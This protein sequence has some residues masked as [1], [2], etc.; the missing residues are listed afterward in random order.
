MVNNSACALLTI[1]YICIH[2]HHSTAN[3]RVSSHTDVYIQYVP[4]RLIDTLHFSVTALFNKCIR[5]HD[6]VVVD[7]GVYLLAHLNYTLLFNILFSG[8]GYFCKYLYVAGD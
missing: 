4:Q 6:I 8:G 3:S 5:F 7:T 1:L 2:G